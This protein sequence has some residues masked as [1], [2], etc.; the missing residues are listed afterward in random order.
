MGTRRGIFQHCKK[1]EDHP[2]ACGDK[3]L[4]AFLTFLRGGSSPRVW[5]Q[6][7]KL[8][9]SGRTG[10]IIPTRVGTRTEITVMLTEL[11]DHPHACGDKNV[12]SLYSLNIV[13]SSPRVWG[14]DK[15]IK[16]ENVSTRIIPTRVGTRRK[17]S[18]KYPSSQ[19]HPHACG[20]KI[21]LLA[22]HFL[23]LGSSPRVWGQ[24]VLSAKNTSP[25]RDHPHAC[26]DK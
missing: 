14:Q 20:D 16:N 13:G 18:A 24:V 2:H 10:R 6:A 1:E 21:R 26:G 25:I 22:K 12:F 15:R 4:N 11:E 7:K 19:D 9:R 23:P 17:H 3:C 5:G 8:S